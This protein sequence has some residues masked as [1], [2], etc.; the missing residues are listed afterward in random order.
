MHHWQ[1]PGSE[2]YCGIVVLL[3]VVFKSASAD[4]YIKAFVRHIMKMSSL[5]SVHKK[6][7]QMLCWLVQS[8]KNIT[9]FS[10]PSCKIVDTDHAEFQWS[11][12]L[13]SIPEVI[14]KVLLAGNTSVIKLLQ[15]SS[16][17]SSPHACDN[18]AQFSL[19]WV[20]DVTVS[21]SFSWR[22]CDHELLW[23]R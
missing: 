6:K 1:T 8:V 15:A 14:T 12:L 10:I 17:Q 11:R 21:L 22:C 4:I 2:G 3:S 5:K 16:S 9:F 13:K 7:E 20:S 18:H 19:Y 23:L